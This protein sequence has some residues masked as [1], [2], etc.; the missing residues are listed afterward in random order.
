MTE[1]LTLRLRMAQVVLKQQDL[2]DMQVEGIA[3]LWKVHALC[4]ACWTPL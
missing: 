3:K 2:V 4:C 1:T